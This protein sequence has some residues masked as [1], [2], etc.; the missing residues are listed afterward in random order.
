M[1]AVDKAV[2]GCA[3]FLP[4]AQ[5]LL[6]EQSVQPTQVPAQRC[7]LGVGCDQRGEVRLI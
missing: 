2:D 5:G 3:T 1:D 6:A 4:R 7:H